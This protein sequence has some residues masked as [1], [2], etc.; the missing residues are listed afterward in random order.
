MLSLNSTRRQVSFARTGSELKQSVEMARSQRDLEVLEDLDHTIAVIQDHVRGVAHGWNSGLYVYGRAGMG[1]TRLV[2][3][4]LEETG[5]PHHRISGHLTPLGL[6]EAMDA[7]HNQVLVLDDTRQLL[8]QPIALELLLAALGTNVDPSRPREVKYQRAERS[9]GEQTIFFSGGIIILSNSELD[10]DDAYDALASRIHVQRLDPT[11]EQV[12]AA[13]R[14]IASSGWQRPN[15]GVTLKAT[16]QECQEVAEYTLGICQQLNRRPDLRIF[17][18]K[19]IVHYLQYREG[20]SV[21][22]WK[23]LVHSSIQGE[24]AQHLSKRQEEDRDRGIAV[25]IL[26]SFRTRQEQ[27]VEWGR[28]T[29]QSQASYYRR[30]REAKQRRLAA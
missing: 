6:F 14:R 7:H 17:C 5:T 30:L 27:I 12:V 21:H 2:I 11:D 9:G 10:S 23:T 4:T 22:D 1:K 18:D 13:I 24:P 20:D 15:K 3:Q 19:A 8:R 16:P 26:K 28:I 25:K 29:G